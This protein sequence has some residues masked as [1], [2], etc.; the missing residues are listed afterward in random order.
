MRQLGVL[1]RGGVKCIRER[2]AMLLTP[3]APS[4]YLAFLKRAR[5]R[6]AMRARSVGEG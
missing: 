5:I 4:F 6:F 1:A 2:P 3:P